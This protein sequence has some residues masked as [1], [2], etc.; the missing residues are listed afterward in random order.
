[1]SKQKFIKQT[2]IFA[3]PELVFAWHEQ[4]GVVEKLTPPWERVKVLERATDIKP[5]A[6]VVFRVY[7]GPI[8]QNWVAEH[9]EYE[10]P[11]LFADIQRKGPFAYWYHRHRFERT[12]RNTTM[13]IDEV[14]YELPLGVLG[15]IFGGAFTRRKLQR[16]F[17]YRHSVVSAAFERK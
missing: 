6:R 12:E 4:P 11:H 3:P 1:M 8:G 10:P 5:G 7:T 9:T 15:E 16:M 14:D 2:E 13:M 17:D